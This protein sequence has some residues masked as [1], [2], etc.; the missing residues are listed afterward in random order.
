MIG[1][2]LAGGKGLRLWPESRRQRPKQLCKLV[3]DNS[4][5]D[6]TIDRL[7]LAGSDHIVIITGDDL[8]PAIDA[9]VS[10]RPDDN[11]IEIL[12][13]PRGR[14]TAPAVGLALSKY[15]NNSGDDILGIFPADHHIL[16]TDNFIQSISLAGKAAEQNFLVTI[17]ITPQ[18][19]DT[20]FGYIERSQYEFSTLP[21]VYPVD[22][23]LEKP[24]LPTAESYLSTGQHMWNSGIYIGKLDIWIKEFAKYL[25]DIYRH[26]TQG[27]T[28]YISAYDQLPDISLD[29]G[30]AEKSDLMAVVPAD[31]GWSDLG[32]WNALA[33]IHPADGADNVF[34]GPD[35]MAFDSKNCL[36]K[37]VEKTVVMFGVDD[38]L[39]VE[40]ADLILVAPRQRVQ[41]IRTIVKS[42]EEMQRDD[43]L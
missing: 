32:S 19:P 10:Q 16:N 35:V 7:R 34:C 26:I 22:S 17:G 3:G 43:L 28:H 42:L 18:R 38:L 12:S 4:M 37:Q 33:E 15:L 31:F 20:G 21:E 25:P 41:D 9:L 6:Q 2:I 36:V 14:N 1:V 11:H 8:L 30:I 13:E 40:T 23:F 39:V 27:Y 24:D 5:L 29:Y